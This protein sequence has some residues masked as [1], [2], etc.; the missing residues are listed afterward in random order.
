ML[1]DKMK[2]NAVV[3][4][5]SRGF[6]K[7]L[8]KS[9]VYDGHN[10][11]FTSRTEKNILDSIHD[12]E[13]PSRIRAG[14]ADRG[15]QG[16]SKNVVGVMVDVSDPDHMDKLYFSVTR[17]MSDGV[18]LWINNAAVSDGNTLFMD[19]PLDRME[20]VVNTNLYGT[21][22][23]TRLAAKLM[24]R[25]PSDRMGHI[26]NVVGAGADG[27]I[28]PE[29]SVYGSTKAGVA[30]FTKTLQRELQHQNIGV[31]VLSPGMMATDLIAEN[32]CE[33]KRKIYN[34]LCEDPDVVAEQLIPVLRSLVKNKTKK[35]YIKC[36]T[37]W[38]ALYKM[39]GG[40]NRIDRFSQ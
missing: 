38:K 39:L 14:V 25:Q 6:G 12:L 11:I 9:L 34:L 16:I 40:G 15:F 36:M 7:S 5:G 1:S 20:S 18:D 2:L 35:S 13:M 17:H 24:L 29:Y 21:L 27:S 37:L 19:T 33:D 31:H 10:V 23:C 4:G 22:F 26:I 3:T 8:V 28:T 32:M 30:Q